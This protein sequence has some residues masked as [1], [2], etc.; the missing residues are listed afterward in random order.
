[1]IAKSHYTVIMYMLIVCWLYLCVDE[2]LDLS[3]TAL[4]L[5]YLPFL[6]MCSGGLLVTSYVHYIVCIAK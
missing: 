2:Q 5:V 3:Y 1:M 6:F 4:L